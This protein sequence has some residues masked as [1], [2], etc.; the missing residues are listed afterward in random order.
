V[1]SDSDYTGL[2]HRIREEGMFVMG[3]GRSGT[4]IAFVKACENFTYTE[5]LVPNIQI[6]KQNKN[7]E[8][9]AA[10]KKTSQSKLQGT[11][12]AGK[13]DV[14]NSLKDAGIKSINIQQ[15]ETAFNNVV[16]DDTGLALLSNLGSSLKKLDPTFDPRNFGFNS[17][18]KFCE[19]LA[20][21]Y[22][23]VIHHDGSTLSLKRKEE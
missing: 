15:I 7:A 9:D 3:I 23:V 5:I 16:D 20:P 11:N 21:D 14:I 4:P 19:S 1:S 22:T 10:G 12:I 17:F 6:D 8:K 2:A 18:R 13:I